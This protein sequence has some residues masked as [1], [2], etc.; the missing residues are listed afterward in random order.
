MN[1]VRR[2]RRRWFGN[3]RPVTHG[4]RPC[5]FG[6]NTFT[7]AHAAAVDSPKNHGDAD[8]DQRQP[9]AGNAWI[10]SRMRLSATREHLQG[11]ISRESKANPEYRRESETLKHGAISFAIER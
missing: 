7:A 6:P 1:F 4:S 11:L 10:G 9:R 2:R 5:A 3:K 8:P